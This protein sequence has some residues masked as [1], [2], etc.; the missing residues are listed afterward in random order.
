MKKPKSFIL[1][2]IAHVRHFINKSYRDNIAALA[3]QSAFFI[4][5]SVIP[6]A[7]FVFVTASIVTGA[8]FQADEL[9]KAAEELP[10]ALRSITQFI[11]DAVKHA[12]SGTAVITA[13]ITLWSAGRG[14]YCITEGISRIYQLP[15]KR[16]WLQKRLFSMVYTV[17]MLMMFITSIALMTANILLSRSIENLLGQSAFMQAIFRPMQYFA[18]SVLLVLFMTLA[19]KFFLN[20]KVPDKRYSTFRALLPGSV[21]TVIAWIILTAGVELYIRYF[22]TS[23]IYG[24]FGTVAVMMMWIYFMMVILLYGIQFNYIYREAFSRRRGHKK[25]KKSTSLPE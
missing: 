22:A 17:I 18:L 16:V 9:T 2:V 1:N 11:L 3:G 20:D 21:L 5:L 10:E 12:T 13:V 25:D 14:L 19:L 23:S 7:M 15:N 6:L 4:I 24:S 8:K